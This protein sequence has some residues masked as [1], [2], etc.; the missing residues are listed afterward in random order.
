[1]ATDVKGDPLPPSHMQGPIAAT[2][3]T[4]HGQQ[5]VHQYPSQ[6]YPPQGAGID[7]GAGYYPPPAYQP[8]PVQQ[9]NTTGVVVIGGPTVPV[10]Q[11][12]VVVRTLRTNVQIPDTYPGVAFC[13]FT[14][15]IIET[16]IRSSIVVSI[17]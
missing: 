13:K 10:A 9:Q 7:Y 3:Y 1:M 2:A 17:L 5:P 15:G 4:Q 8:Q 16:V 12:V 14:P 6:P 11:N